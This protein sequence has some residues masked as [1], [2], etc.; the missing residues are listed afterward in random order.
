MHGI[1]IE[2]CKI[3]T[4]NFINQKGKNHQLFFLHRKTQNSSFSIYPKICVPSLMYLKLTI[5][6]KRKSTTK[7]SVTKVLNTSV[8]TINKVINQDLQLKNAKKH[9]I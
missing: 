9:N 2:I 3:K 4:I 1:E 7:K 8:A 6:R 5:E